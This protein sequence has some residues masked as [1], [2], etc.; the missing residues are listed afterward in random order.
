MPRSDPSGFPRHLLAGFALALCAACQGAGAVRTSP[1][2][3]V[4]S[5]GLVDVASLAPS[6]RV[7]MRYAGSDNFVGTPVRGYEAPRCYLLRPAA[8]ALARVQAGLQARHRSLVVY[9]CYRPVRA[10]RHFVEW[11]RDVGEQRTKAAHYPRVDKSHLFRDGYIAESSGH[12]RGA[13]VDLGL[14]R[15][16]ANGSC[17]PFDMGTGFDLFDPRAHT[18]SPEVTQ[19][20]RANRHLLR[21]AMAAGGFVNYP[22]EWWHYTLRPEPTPDTAYDAPVR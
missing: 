5:A 12:S 11:A 19:L 6:L 10:V 20:Q 16:E 8:E 14:L 18:D 2:A 4:R 13:T 3:D 1:A 15:C 9:D 21:E 17:T 22:K 7:D